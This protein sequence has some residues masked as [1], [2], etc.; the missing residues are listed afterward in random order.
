M[1][2]KLSAK[3]EVKSWDESP[4]DGEGNLPKMTRALVT[5]EYSGDIEG[6]S[7]TQWLMAYANDASATFVGLE[8]ITGT[9]AGGQGTLVLRHSGSYA[10]GAAKAELTVVEGANSGEMLSATGEGEFLADPKGSVTLELTY[11]G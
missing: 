4:F 7:T 1:Q 5:K 8:R 6:T 3:F 2:A 10:D 9:I 11:P